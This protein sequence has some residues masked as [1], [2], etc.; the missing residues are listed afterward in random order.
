MAKKAFL[1]KKLFTGKLNLEL[2]KRIT[3]CFLCSVALYALRSR[4]MDTDISGQKKI[5]SFS[6][7][8]WR[9]MERISCIYISE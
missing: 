6:M 1:D 7:W 2:K 3:K 5:T 8:I 9:R 4:D